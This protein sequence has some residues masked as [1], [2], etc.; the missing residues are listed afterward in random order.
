MVIKLVVNVMYSKSTKTVQYQYKIAWRKKLH[1]N[2]LCVILIRV[3][4]FL[5]QVQTGVYPSS[6]PVPNFQNDSTYNSHYST[7]GKYSYSPVPQRKASSNEADSIDA[8]FTQS[9]LNAQPIK[10]EFREEYYKDE[11]KRCGTNL[12]IIL[13]LVHL[14]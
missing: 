13:F 11:R 4:F 2:Y 10:R 9:A 5:F 7:L 3:N 12:A 6:K 1:L 14:L 8:I